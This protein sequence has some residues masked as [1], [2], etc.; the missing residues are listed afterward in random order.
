MRKFV[1]GYCLFVLQLLPGYVLAQRNGPYAGE[2]VKVSSALKQMHNLRYEYHMAETYPNGQTDQLKGEVFVGNDRKLFYNSNDAFT[3]LYT[4]VWF[5]KADHREKAIAL[6]NLN[7]HLR[8]DFKLQ[9]EK[10]LFAQ[11]TVSLYLD[12]LVQ[13]YATVKGLKRSGDTVRMELAFPAN[14]QIK[15]ISLEFNEKEK[16]LIS[17]TMRVFQPWHND[18][19]GKDKGTTEVVTCKNFKR[20]SDNKAFGTDKFFVI[21]KNKVT[22]KKY[23]SYNLTS[24]L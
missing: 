9:M 7:K 18:E 4:D 11:N 22:L 19:F 15:T 16:I 3:M 10:D 2:L 8:K 21:K 1:T 20:I 14:M 13:R 24:K 5:Y 6:V 12:S 17:Y 23:G